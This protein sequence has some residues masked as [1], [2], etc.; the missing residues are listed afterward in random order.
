MS[1]EVETA[2]YVRADVQGSRL[3]DEIVFFDDRVGKYFATGPVGADI[4]DMLD[5]PMNL[6]TICAKLL[7]AYEI[8]E[9]TC[10]LQVFAFL[11]KMTELKLVS[12]TQ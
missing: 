2:K 5:S 12:V 3:G 4:W 1:G 10:R 6:E 11:E 8:E 9:D 7:A